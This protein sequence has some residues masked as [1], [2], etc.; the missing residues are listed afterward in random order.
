MS[1]KVFLESSS[2]FSIYGVVRFTTYI[3]SAMALYLEDFKVAAIAFGFGALLGFIRRIARIWEWIMAK[4]KL[5]FHTKQNLKQYMLKDGSRFW[6]KDDENALLYRTL[7]LKSK[8]SEVAGIFTNGML[9]KE[10]GLDVWM[11][12][13]FFAGIYSIK[14]VR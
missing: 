5:P 4:K 11:G 12:C 2:D 1:R 8:G 10:V 13:S 6:A 7:I 9:F 3:M 14:N